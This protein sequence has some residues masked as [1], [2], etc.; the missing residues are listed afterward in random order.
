[1]RV[2]PFAVLSLLVV[3]PFAHAQQAGGCSGISP[4]PLPQR[5]TILPP[6]AVELFANT[7]RLGAPSGVLAQSYDES[8]SVDRVLTRMKLD[9]CRETAMATPAASAN[10]PAAYKPKT[11]FDNSPWRFDMNQN[12]KRMT[13]DEF[14]AWMKARGVRVVKAK[15]AAA[16]PAPAAP[17][18]A[19][20]APASQVPAVAEPA[21]KN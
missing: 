12:G 5:A 6:V 17:G 8:Q 16:V 10:D 11:Q 20:T 15:P 19:S 13:A 1:M 2:L 9:G 21:G 14:D 18:E 4:Q 7:T 3:A